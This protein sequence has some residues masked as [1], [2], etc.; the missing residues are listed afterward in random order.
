VAPPLPRVWVYTGDMVSPETA[1][2]A[3]RHGCALYSIYATTEAGGIGF[4]CER[5]EGLHLNVDLCCVRI[6]D[7][8]GR[9]MPDGEDGEL[10]VST[11]GNRAMALLNFR[12]GDRGR[13]ATDPCPCGRGLPVLARLDG[14]HSDA[15]TLADGRRLSSLYVEGLFRIE[16]RAARQVQL[17]QRDPRTICWRLV[18]HTGTDREQLRAALIK[19]GRDVLG[20]GTQLAV[21]FVEEIAPTGEGKSRRVIAEPGAR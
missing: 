21:E 10:I 1:I 13:L 7:E 4:Q 12:I 17:V 18:T 11:L 19:R 20:A 2:L 14:R 9:T 6:V 5:R 8:L 3:E 16:L 15:V